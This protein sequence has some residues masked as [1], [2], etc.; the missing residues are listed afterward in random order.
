ML[1][2]EH[3]LRRPGT[4]AALLVLSSTLTSVAEWAEDARKLRDALPAA[5]REVLDRHEAAGTYDDPE[6]E[7][8]MTSASHASSSTASAVRGTPSSRRARTRRCWR[9]PSVTWSWWDA[10]WLVAARGETPKARPL[11]GRGRSESQ[12]GR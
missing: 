4:L 8:A 11:R 2:L 10:S 6:Y 3:A 7:E 12:A 1:A 9:R 5:V